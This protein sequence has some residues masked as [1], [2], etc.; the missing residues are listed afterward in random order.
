VDLLVE[1]KAG[2]VKWNGVLDF[3]VAETLNE[4]RKKAV[5]GKWAEAMAMADEKLRLFLSPIP[6]PGSIFWRVPS[7]SNFKG[8]GGKR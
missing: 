6:T 1:L 3:S 4:I 5:A 2:Q 7:L 8:G